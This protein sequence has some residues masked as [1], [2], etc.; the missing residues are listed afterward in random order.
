MVG[1]YGIHQH[2]QKRMRQRGVTVHDIKHAIRSS[3]RI[4]AYA[5]ERILPPEF[6][7]WRVVGRDLEG[8]ELSL[9][10]QLTVDHLGGFFV[11]VTVF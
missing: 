5:P 3:P 7:S 6:S 1:R 8:D 4:E 11:V 10:L 9:G 2:A